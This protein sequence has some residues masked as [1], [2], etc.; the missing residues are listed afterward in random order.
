M[1]KREAYKYK[2][3]KANGELIE[4]IVYALDQQD[5]FAKVIDK[6][7][8]PE[9]IEKTGAADKRAYERKGIEI[10]F[11][12]SMFG[13]KSRIKPPA[14]TV[15]AVKKTSPVYRANFYGNTRNISAGGILFNTPQQLNIGAIINVIMEL[16][17]EDEKINSQCRV[18]RAYEV[19]RDIKYEIAVCFIDLSVS[20][21]KILNSKI[22]K[23]SRR[24]DRREYE[25][26]T[27]EIKLFFDFNKIEEVKEE[28]LQQ[29][30][31]PQVVKDKNKLTGKTIDISAG[32]LFFQG[33]LELRKDQIIE[34]D[35]Q[36]EGTKK[37]IQ[38]LAKVVR[39][40]T[41]LNYDN[42]VF[43]TAIF[44]LN[45]SN[46]DRNWLNKYIIDYNV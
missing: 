42:P 12:Y 9:V 13:K 18:I 24:F 36:F 32:G 17:D 46:V 21:K 34:V 20:A 19:E 41:K 5:A 3:L 26:F 43:Y 44:F 40:S 11:S 4:G 33:N 23:I 37:T 29:P 7:Y 22:R 15:Q 16:P 45:I 14:P 10:D 8:T 25:R 2:A 38:T 27:E 1:K 31:Q 30:Q 35:M 28:Q 6:G 39:K